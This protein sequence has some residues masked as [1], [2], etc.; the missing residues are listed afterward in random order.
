MEETIDISWFNLSLGYL[1]LL[2]PILIFYYFKIK[3]IKDTLIAAFRMTVQLLLVGVY[4][5]YLFKWDNVYINVIWVV[6]MIVAASFTVV[7]RSNVSVKLYYIP[8]LSGLLISVLLVDFYFLSIVIKSKPLLTARYIIPITGMLIG[9]TM[10]SN[11]VVL[12]SFYSLLKQNLSFYYYALGNGATRKEA[13]AP[14]YKIAIKQ[15]I[16]PNIATMA[17][18][19][20]VSLPG[21]MTGQILGGNDPSL[22][23]RYQIVIMMSVFVIGAISAALSLIIA[24][25]IV[26]DEFNK[27]R[28]EVL[29][30]E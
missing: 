2:I 6:V 10:K 1:L 18:V 11:I 15:G 17:I 19:G 3:L 20:L 7:K 13:L 27:P 22:A 25:K 4:L 14:F 8:V 29:E 5:D 28:Q 21:M 26:F 9:N 24:N 30:V 12:N 23:V 16:N